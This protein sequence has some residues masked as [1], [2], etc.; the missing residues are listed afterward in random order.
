MTGKYSD[1][2]IYLD[3]N[4]TTK[5]DQGVLKAMLPYLKEEYG[6]PSSP[7][8]LG[9]RAKKGLER[10]REEVAL[11]LGCQ[12]HEV[13]FTSGGSESNNM[14]LKGLKNF[15]LLPLRWSIPQS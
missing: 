9:T 13:I 4:A 15:I 10:A 7:Y 12:N 6:N 2:F 5:V 11:L 1:R 3:H 14:V 8:L